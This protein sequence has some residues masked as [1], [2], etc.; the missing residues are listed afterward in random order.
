MSYGAKI[1]DDAR[2]L[3]YYLDRILKGASPGT[4]PVERPSRFY[5]TIN[6]RTAKAIGLGVP[7]PLLQRADLL[8]E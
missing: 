6:L 5:R 1:Q 3:S 8:I 7:S 2:R 4:L